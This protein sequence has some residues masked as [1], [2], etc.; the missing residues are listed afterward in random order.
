MIPGG[1]GRRAQLLSALVARTVKLGGRAVHRAMRPHVL[2]P[3]TC[4]P[5]LAAARARWACRGL[6]RAVSIRRDL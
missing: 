2:V 1:L 4:G 3:L 5:T 6:R